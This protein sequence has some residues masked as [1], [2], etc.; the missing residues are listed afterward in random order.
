MN[1]HS[2]DAFFE[3]LVLPVPRPYA[4]RAASARKRVA[5]LLHDLGNPHLELRCIHLAG[6][7]GKGSTALFAESISQAAGLKTGTFTS[8]HLE[9]WG[10]RFRI[11]GHPVEEVSL[12]AAINQICPHVRRL[13]QRHP[14]DPPTFFDTLTAIGLWLFAEAGIDLAIIEAGIGARLD[15]TSITPAIVACVTSIELEH[16]DKLGSTL[17]A[18][19]SE[20]AGVI[21]PGRPLVLGQLT[22]SAEKVLLN[23]AA[24]VKSPVSQLGRDFKAQ[25]HK[26]DKFH[27]LLNYQGHGQRLQVKLEQPAPYIAL[28]AALA[29]ECLIQTEL[30][31]TQA[32]LSAAH[33]ALPETRLPGRVEI[34]KTNPVVV[35]DAAHTGVSIAQ[36]AEV[37]KTFDSDGLLAVLSVTKGKDVEAIFSP[38]KA[39]ITRVIA[40]QADAARSIP[41][42]ILAT[43][44]QQHWPCEVISTVE[45][46]ARAL[47]LAVEEREKRGIGIC[48]T[49]SVYLAGTARRVL[50]ELTTHDRRVLRNN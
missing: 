20:K 48:I 28:N 10:E 2:I 13:L 9:H 32:F 19:A 29:L 33:Q 30:T 49:G 27:S 18:I 38:L 42:Q 1:S 4:Q 23:A 34:L 16:T 37:L 47:A 45:Q 36:L 15:A 41:A 5:D 8:P 17:A 11:G 40:T 26:V 25:A 6:S 46:P 12:C 31:S 3:S 14:N 43:R 21:R 50:R 22:P 7:K 35:V 39:V 24:G 44:L